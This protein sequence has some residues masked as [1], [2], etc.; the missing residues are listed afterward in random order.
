MRIKFIEQWKF[1]LLGRAVP[2][3]KCDDVTNEGRVHTLHLVGRVKDR[4]N[5]II[6]T[7]DAKGWEKDPEFG[8]ITLI[9]EKGIESYPYV[10][11]AAGKTCGLYTEPCAFPN[12]EDVI[13]KAA[14]MDDIAEAMDLNKSIKNMAIG[15]IIGIGLGVVFISPMLSAFMK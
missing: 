5:S 11:S 7:W 8:K 1:R 2:V 3:V 6:N 10:V 4:A 14:T 12:R 9:D 15:I 13:G